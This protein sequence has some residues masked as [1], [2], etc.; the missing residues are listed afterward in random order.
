M[1]INVNI[2]IEKS[3]FFFVRVEILKLNVLRV[4]DGMLCCICVLTLS[5]KMWKADIC[6]DMHKF[7]F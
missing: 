1:K 2:I 5:F 3:T 7:N 6:T 4:L